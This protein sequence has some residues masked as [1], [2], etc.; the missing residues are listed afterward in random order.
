MQD[1]G[2]NTARAS[3]RFPGWWGAATALALFFAYAPAR[4]QETSQVVDLTLESAV[5]M[6]MDNSYR[7]R[8]LR[9][10]VDRTRS[11]LQAQRAGLKSRVYM[12]IAAP[13]FKRISEHRWNSNLQRD[14]IV[15]Q[16]SNLWQMDVSVEQPVMILGYPTN[17]YL[18]LNNRVYRYN[19]I[20]QNDDV[21]YYNRY[22]LRYRQPVFQPN[23][24]KNNLEEA[25]L[26]LERSELAFQSDAVNIIDDIADEYYNLFELAYER[27]IYTEHVENLERATAAAQQRIEADPTRAIELSQA[28]VALANARERLQQARSNFRL[29][30][31][32]MKQRLRLPESDSLAVDPRIDVTPVVVDVEKAIEYGV[33]LRPQLRTLDIQ[34][35][36]EEI[37][38]ENARGSNSFRMNLEFTYGREMEDPILAELLNEPSNSYTVGVNAYIPIWD[39][40]ARSA[41]VQAQKLRLQRTHLS[42]EETREGIQL[43]IRNVVQNLDEYQQRA[44]NMEQNL[45]LAKSVSEQSLDQYREGKVT[46]LDLLQAF[47]RQTATAD[48]F[49]DAYLGYRNAALNLQQMTF[50]DFENQVPILRRFGLRAGAE[51]S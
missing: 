45:G 2:P 48:N 41:R 46:M 19:Q 47:E 11:L 10:D 44:Q 24:L 3:R 29:A 28:Q 50:F 4:A 51:E 21:T 16:H 8:R 5:E 20:R 22:F 18:S 25:T 17:G 37:F 38:L 40:G 1:Y 49:L 39:W 27:V 36:R 43:E 12:N 14:E 42:I 33:T 30:A 34:R 15:R 7:V 9:L 32:R 13:E 31:S 35:R 26:E 23:A 6:A